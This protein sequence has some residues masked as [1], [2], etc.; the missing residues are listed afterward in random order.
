VVGN[1]KSFAALARHTERMSTVRREMWSYYSPSCLAPL[2]YM[3]HLGQT[4]FIGVKVAFTGLGA[5]LLVA[6]EYFP[7]AYRGLLWMAGT[8]AGV[9]LVHA[10]ILLS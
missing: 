9:L 10:G 8:Y 3:L 6:H 7:L 4:P 2:S 5:W 1:A